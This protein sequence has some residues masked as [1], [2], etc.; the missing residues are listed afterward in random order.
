M[1]NIN[2]FQLLSVSGEQTGPFLYPRTLVGLMGLSV[3]TGESL[4]VFRKDLLGSEVMDR[5][6]LAKKLG[7][8][9][10]YLATTADAIGYSLDEILSATMEE[11]K[12]AER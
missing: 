4:D 11:M 8:V 1:V 5:K 6:A 9:A 2:E 12:N 7:D 10:R 3:K